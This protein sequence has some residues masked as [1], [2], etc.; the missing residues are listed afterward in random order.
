MLEISNVK[1]YK[2]NIELDF[3][4]L[5]TGVKKKH[6]KCNIQNYKQICNYIGRN[7][8]NDEFHYLLNFFENDFIYKNGN[9]VF[10]SSLILRR[11]NFK[12]WDLLVLKCR[13]PPFFK[14]ICNTTYLQIY[15][16]HEFGFLSDRTFFM[17]IINSHIDSFRSNKYIFK[18]I[19]ENFNCNLVLNKYCGKYEL[20]CANL[21]KANDIY[22]IS[23]VMCAYIGICYYLFMK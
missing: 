18:Q 17:N 11:R 4:G 21:N 7:L 16:N 14:D 15:Y 12:Y 3:L 22:H 19:A 6:L 13:I 2:N 23:Q 10:N 20:I 1:K 9:S 5:E 8:N